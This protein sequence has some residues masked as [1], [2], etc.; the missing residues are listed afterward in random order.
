LKKKNKGGQVLTKSDPTTSVDF[1]PLDVRA[2]A[3][4]TSVFVLRK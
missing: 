3:G 2:G 1:V 4:V